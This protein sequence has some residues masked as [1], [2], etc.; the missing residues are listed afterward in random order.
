MTTPFA[1]KGALGELLKSWAPSYQP[2]AGM[3]D[4]GICSLAQ[5]ANVDAETLAKL[6]ANV[7]NQTEG[8]QHRMHAEDIILRA[9]KS[10][11]GWILGW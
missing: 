7:V 6:L 1:S 9:A 5:L 3:F 10:G 2:Y 8:I 11:A 4:L